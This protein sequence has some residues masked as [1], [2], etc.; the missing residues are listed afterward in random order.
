MLGVF[1]AGLFPGVNYY[2][3]WFV[4]TS[5]RASSLSL[6][7]IAGIVGPSSESEQLS[8]FPQRLFQEPSVV[9]SP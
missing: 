6:A 2:L 4:Q 1:E 9:F 3:S 8:S 5:L 7:L